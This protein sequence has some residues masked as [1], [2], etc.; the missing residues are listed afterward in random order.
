M[1]K[2][3][4]TLFGLLLSILYSIF[5]CTK[6]SYNPFFCKLPLYFHIKSGYVSIGR[7]FSCRRSCSI[8]V[9]GGNLIIGQSVFFN[10]SVSINCQDEII[11]GDGCIFG[12]GVKIYD[13]DHTISPGSGAD[14]QNFSHSTV[15]LGNNVWLGAN[16]IILKGVTIGE[17]AVVAAGSIV[18]KSIEPNTTFYQKRSS[19]TQYHL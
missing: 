13:H 3:I 7:G 12:E 9:T 10:Q 14:R 19:S 5:Y 6:T 15:K 1:I 4:Y 17:N 8:N 11:V 16:V 18:T 2:I